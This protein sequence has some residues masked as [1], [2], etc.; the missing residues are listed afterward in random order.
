[1]TKEEYSKP[2]SEK[3]EK[4]NRTAKSSVSDKMASQNGYI[5]KVKAGLQKGAGGEGGS[6]IY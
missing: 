3:P 1:M 5:S 6:I 2:P 4:Q